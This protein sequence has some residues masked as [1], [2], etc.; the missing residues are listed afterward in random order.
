MAARV[1]VKS[2]A[3]FLTR[4]QRRQDTRVLRCVSLVMLGDFH[5]EL[6][7]LPGQHGE[8]HFVHSRDCLAWGSSKKK[9]R[10]TNRRPFTKWGED[11]VVDSIDS[12]NHILSSLPM[13]CHACQL[14]LVPT[15][16]LPL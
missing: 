1:P 3:H 12:I 15:P 11:S 16:E 10:T 2:G 14:P 6:G 5:E 8:L 7:Y 4:Q 9:N 13:I